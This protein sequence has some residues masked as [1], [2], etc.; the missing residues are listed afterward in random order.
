MNLKPINFLTVT[1]AFNCVETFSFKKIFG[2][3]CIQIQLLRYIS[4]KYTTA[5]RLVFELMCWRPIRLSIK[6]VVRNHDKPA[7]PSCCSA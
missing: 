3:C 5:Q 7:V 4:Y 6:I 2:V 1:V